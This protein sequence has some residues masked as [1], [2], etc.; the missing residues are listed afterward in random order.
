MIINWPLIVI[1]FC[2]SIPGCF[3]AMTRLVHFLLPHNTDEVKKRAS[4]LV[5]FQALFMVLAMSFTGTI[6][7]TRTGLGDPVLTPL[8]QGK[9]VLNTFLANLLPTLLYAV[10]CFILFCILYYGVVRSILDEQSLEVMTKLRR[11]LKIDGC[12]LFG[13]IAE[14][15]IAR[16]GFMNLIA[17]FALLFSKQMSVSVIA[18]SIFFKWTDVCYWSDTCLHRSRL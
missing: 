12:I 15:V 9:E 1:L 16:W 5:V 2:I 3:I 17:F 18:S 7:S 6:L 14:E 11:S 13:G 8:L 10:A 4:R